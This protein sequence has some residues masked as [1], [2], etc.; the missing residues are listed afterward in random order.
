MTEQEEID[1]LIK[2]P[3]P[4]PRRTRRERFWRVVAGIT[5]GAGIAGLTL[6]AFL[7][8][9][10]P[11]S[12]CLNTDLKQR[13]A[14]SAQDAAAHIKFADAQQAWAA[15]LASVLEAPKVDADARYASFLIELRTYGSQLD[16]YA[17]QLKKDQAVRTAHPLGT[18]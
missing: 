5:G 2:T 7:Y 18:C 8:F 11:S 17:M 6:G 16:A 15:S 13:N 14:P 1:E 4:P 12:A 3:P 9:T 10:T